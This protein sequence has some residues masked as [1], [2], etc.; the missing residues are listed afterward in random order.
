MHMTVDEQ[1]RAETFGPQEADPNGK[2]P[3]E[4]GAKLD[5]GKNRLG[6]VLCGFARALQEVGAVGT[7]GANKYTDNGWTEVPD[8]ERRYTDAMLRHLM[9]EA[10]GEE[11]DPD[12]GLRHAAHCCW[13][14]LARLDLA[15]R[16]APNDK[17]QGAGGSFIA[18]GSLERRVLRL[19]MTTEEKEM[20]VLEAINYRMNGGGCPGAGSLGE[21]AAI[22]E[23]RA[24]GSASR[25]HTAHL[26]LHSGADD[27]TPAEVASWFHK[28][29]AT[30]VVVSAVLYDKDNNI[31]NGSSIDDGV[32][33]WDV[34]YFLPQ[35]VEVTG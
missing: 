34:S 24:D 27:L 23:S 31:L 21:C 32:R 11:R 19:A 9:R 4:A 22:T 17:A 1:H 20:N 5:V 14:A 2:Q 3:N 30:D 26:Y 8:G 33:P 28:L 15:L 7:Y 6:L 10:T 29:G 12:S 25:Y 16:K 35:N 18:G 13:N